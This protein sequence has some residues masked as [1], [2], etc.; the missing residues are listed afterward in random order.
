MDELD[1]LGVDYEELNLKFLRE[2]F[3][4]NLLPDDHF[5]K[6]LY[7]P[8]TINFLDGSFPTID[9]SLQFNSE[10]IENKCDDGSTSIYTGQV[11]EQGK[12]DGYGRILFSDGALY[13]GTV[14]N[15]NRHG[16]G[17]HIFVSGAVYIGEY[18]DG[19][20][21]GFGEYT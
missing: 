19:L 4:R 14:K 3:K 16:R 15:G 10:G 12:V 18:K 17:R 1:F 2:F 6:D 21:N 11:N 8:P 13:E 7:T 20:R 5:Y 9:H